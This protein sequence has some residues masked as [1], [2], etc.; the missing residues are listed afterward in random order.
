M[1]HGSLGT[2]NNESAS[3]LSTYLNDSYNNEHS[4]ESELVIMTYQLV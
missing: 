3:D 2:P 4:D 1:P